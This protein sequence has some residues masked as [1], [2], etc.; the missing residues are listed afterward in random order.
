MNVKLEAAMVISFRGE[1]FLVV[2]FDADGCVRLRAATGSEEHLVQPGDLVADPTFT[3]E[4]VERQVMS[5]S[6]VFW[7]SL[8]EE[9]QRPALAREEHLR[10]VLTGFRLGRPD[11]CFPGEPR[12]A[13]RNASRAKR[14]RA[15][16]A[17][18]GVSYRQ[19]NRWLEAYERAGQHPAALIDRNAVRTSSRLGKQEGC[20]AEAIMRVAQQRTDDSDVTLER[21]KEL[22]QRELEAMGNGEVALP[23]QP[24]F[25]RLVRRFA[26]E[27]THHAKRRRSAASRGT[28][29]PFGKIICTRPG[30][31]VLIDITPFDIL[32]RSEFDGRELRLRLILA[33]DLYSRAIVAARLVEY[34][35]KGV[36]ITMVLL[37]IIHP[38]RPHP[39]WPRLEDDARLPYLGVPEGVMLAAHDM[40]EGVPLLNVPPILPEA[41]VVDN[42]MVFL[43]GYFRDLCQRL[44]IDIMLA[45]PGTGSDKAHVERLFLHIRHSLAERLVGYVGPHVLARGRHVEALHFPW[46]VQF[47]VTQWVARYY[48]RKPH[49]SLHHPMT[50]KV[51]LSPEQMFAFGV[52]HAG[53]LTVPLGQD[54]YYL[55]LRTVSRVIGD[56]GVRL[57]GWQYDSDALNPYRNVE[58]GE[59]DGKWRFKVD[60]RDP[61]RIHF[62]QPH[63]GL[64]HQIP[65]RD[66]D[67]PSRPFQKELLETVKVMI[68]ERA[69]TDSSEA[70]KQVRRE[71]G[72]AYAARVEKSLQAVEKQKEAGFT[73]RQKQEIAWRETARAQQ[74]EMMGKQRKEEKVQQDARVD[75]TVELRLEEDDTR[76]IEVVGDEF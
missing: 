37:D 1:T 70:L 75:P 26:P 39:S 11:V 36:D 71:M 33:M 10:E 46:E 73:T 66:A 17:E 15:K 59:D 65:E 32:A 63:T 4:G 48:N 21:L 34:E 58:S 23:S 7:D 14:V 3:V 16:A 44:G 41:V 45:R 19:V 57:D 24:T 60:P 28:Q 42:G 18:L 31:Y 68:E 69:G 50:P 52:Q 27:Q 29:R 2:N 56:T 43:S 12:D 13:Y 8:P 40:P 76:R 35:P 53:H 62:L 55:A 64:W 22:V 5:P 6:Q 47:E 74:E 72:D 51:K 9:L 54:A 38:V 67:Y 49:A 30:Q 61:T 20:I 25:N